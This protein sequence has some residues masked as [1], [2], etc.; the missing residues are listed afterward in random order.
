MQNNKDAAPQTGTHVGAV[1]NAV[2][3][4]RHLAH[5][6]R[7]EGVAQI[8]RATHINTSTCFN[9]LRTLQSEGLLDFHELEKVY[10]ISQGMLEL[11]LPVLATNPLDLIRPV[12]ARLSHE[13]NSLIALW[14]ITALERLVLVDRAVP[15][16]IVHIDMQ[17]GT[18]LP[19]YIGALGRCVAAQRDLNEAELERRFFELRWA[20]PPSFEEYCRQVKDAG[21]KGYAIDAGNLYNLIDIVAAVV[22]DAAGNPRFGLS[23]IG[24]SGQKSPEQIDVIGRSLRD[25]AR[26]LS[27]SLYGHKAPAP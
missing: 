26:K 13:Q 4:L 21:Q 2:T 20:S 22:T 16:R 24:I 15:N 23:A 14:K 10:S 7:P 9:I 11:A 25:A 3:I 6:A 1:G 17:I 5:A 19:S 18:R 8:A 27:L 12:L